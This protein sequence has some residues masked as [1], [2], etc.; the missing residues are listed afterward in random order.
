MQIFMHY[1]TDGCSAPEIY[2]QEKKI[3]A[4]NYEAK[5]QSEKPALLAS[6][7]LKLESMSFLR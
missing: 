2:A 1:Y 6:G 7:T 4:Q 5:T 3:K